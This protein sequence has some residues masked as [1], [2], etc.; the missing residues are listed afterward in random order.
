M[1]LKNIAHNLEATSQLISFI[2]NK[3]SSSAFLFYGVNS[4]I[5]KAFAIEF[6]KALNCLNKSFGCEACS[7]CNE[8][9]KNIFPDCYSYIS[10][11]GVD[12]LREVVQKVS[13]SGQFGAKKVM[14]IIN[15]NELTKIE[16]NL[17]LKIVEEP[18]KDTYII[19]LSRSAKIQPTIFSRCIPIKFTPILPKDVGIEQEVFRTLNSE[20]ETIMPIELASEKKYQYNNIPEILENF[21]AGIAWKYALNCAIENYLEVRSSIGKLE[22]L[23]WIF[24]IEKA[25]NKNRELLDIF[26]IQCIYKCREKS[27]LSRLIYIKNGLKANLSIR[28][29]LIRFLEMVK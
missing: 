26:M 21:I 23:E 4:P 12:E 19:F 25:I 2:K 13:K 24:K 15:A 20:I 6:A 17:L 7:S 10:R 5:L 1:S 18:P 27:Y 14:F 29:A 16:A 9:E 3:N 8:I 22:C 11:S 28:L